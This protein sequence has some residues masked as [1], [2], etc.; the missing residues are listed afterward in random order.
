MGLFE[1]G[2]GIRHVVLGGNQKLGSIEF[3]HA[4]TGEVKPC[5]WR[6]NLIR[7]LLPEL[8]STKQ[9]IGFAYN[10][11][12]GM[13]AMY[14]IGLHPGAPHLIAI[15]VRA[16]TLID[17]AWVRR[18]GL[19]LSTY[20]GS[21]WNWIDPP[22]TR[23][24]THPYTWVRVDPITN[25]IVYTEYN[26]SISADEVICVSLPRITD[27]QESDVDVGNQLTI[28]PNPVN[29]YIIINYLANNKPNKIEIYSSIGVLVYEYH[30]DVDAAQQ[31][32][33]DTH[34]WSSGM[35]VLRV[36]EHSGAYY[37]SFIVSH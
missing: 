22:S 18:R 27:V 5:A 14:G 11:Y 33:I 30:T 3:I 32:Q 4:I 31:T 17:S 35:Y 10:W 21:T 20:T 13:G 8:D 12:H 2:F 19:A 16:D 25:T 7:S 24:Y 37:R 6:N 1:P 9:E 15:V 23:A 29:D 26:R 34:A 28:Y 36:T